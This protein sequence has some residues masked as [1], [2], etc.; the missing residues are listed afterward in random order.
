MAGPTF[1]PISPAPD[2]K[3]AKSIDQNNSNKSTKRRKLG[4]V[5]DDG[6]ITRLGEMEPTW[7]FFQLPREVR[8]MIYSHLCIFTQRRIIHTD[9][10]A[11]LGSPETSRTEPK[12]AGASQKARKEALSMYY[13]RNKFAV[14]ITDFCMGPFLDWTDFIGLKN[15]RRIKD[16]ILI[17]HGVDDEGAADPRDW[18]EYKDD[19]Y[20]NAK[21]EYHGLAVMSGRFKVACELVSKLHSRDLDD[22]AIDDLI[23]TCNRMANASMGANYVDNYDWDLG[24]MT[25]TTYLHGEFC[26]HKCPICDVCS[27]IEGSYGGCICNCN[28]D[29]RDPACDAKEPKCC[30]Y[31]P[32]AGSRRPHR[33]G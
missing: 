6:S 5:V 23:A 8:D 32:L 28:E 33:S 19:S 27:C 22:A 9:D 15:A 29:L 11:F 21:I 7:G 12:I 1:S 10:N 14:V 17:F 18:L 4:S 31:R 2:Q 25:E 3:N 26:L 20:R 30:H 13:A 24:D 16:L